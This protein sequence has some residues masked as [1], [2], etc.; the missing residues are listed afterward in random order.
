M[1]RDY[2][3]RLALLARWRFSSEEAED[4]ISDYREMIAAEPGTYAELVER[5]GTPWNAVRQIPGAGL[6]RVWLA[7]FALSFGCLLVPAAWVLLYCIRQGLFSFIWESTGKMLWFLIPDSY[8]ESRFQSALPMMLILGLVAPLLW[9]RRGR[10]GREPLTRGMRLCL[11]LLLVC[12][13]WLWLFIW[14]FLCDF[15]GFIQLW[16]HWNESRN[17]WIIN[18]VCLGVPAAAAAVCGTVGLLFSRLK[19]RRWRAV[20]ALS[21]LLSVLSAA[22]FSMFTSLSFDADGWQEMQ[23][24]YYAAITVIGLVGTGVSLC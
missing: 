1:K 19:N 22:V 5:F 9:F 13:A 18:G 15:D 3:S 23:L 7:A 10:K 12:L 17:V 2:I 24:K 16:S 8:V 6:S 4:I 20:F 21:L 14:K 11:L